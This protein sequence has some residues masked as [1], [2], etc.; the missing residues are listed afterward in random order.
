MKGADFQEP[1]LRFI[2]GF[3][4][5]TNVTFIPAESQ[6][7]EEGSASLAAAAQQIEQSARQ[8]SLV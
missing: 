8:P 7:R 2:L 5:I 4:G 1:Y 3:M 6:G